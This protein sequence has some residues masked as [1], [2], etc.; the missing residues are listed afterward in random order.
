VRYPCGPL[1]ALI[2]AIRSGKVDGFIIAPD[3]TVV[4]APPAGG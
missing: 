4:A 1:S 2:E 3:G